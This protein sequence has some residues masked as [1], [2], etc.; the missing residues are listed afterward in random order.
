[1]D[2]DGLDDTAVTVWVARLS[3]GDETIVTAWS[4]KDKAQAWC[5][6]ELNRGQDEIIWS[7]SGGSKPGR[8]VTGHYEGGVVAIIEQIEVMDPISLSRQYPNEM[9]AARHVLND[10]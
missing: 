4:F 6:H 8:R 3:L 10:G 2:L 1:M 9:P 7:E 5:G